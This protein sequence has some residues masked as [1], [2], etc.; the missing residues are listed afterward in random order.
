MLK[1]LRKINF[2]WQF[3]IFVSVSIVALLV[4]YADCGSLYKV[5]CHSVI[6][7]R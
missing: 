6:L 5:D 1:K 7:N 2:K 3:V 4:L